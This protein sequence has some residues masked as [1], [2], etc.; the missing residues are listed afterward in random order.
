M[1]ISEYVHINMSDWELLPVHAT[2]IQ[3][4]LT[5]YS[6]PERLFS[7]NSHFDTLYDIKTAHMLNSD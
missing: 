3:Q 1:R 5:K 6:L 4:D 2:T 7:I